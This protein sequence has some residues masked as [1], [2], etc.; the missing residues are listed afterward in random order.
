MVPA[1]SR[2]FGGFPFHAARATFLVQILPTSSLGAYLHWRM[3]T[4][5]L[6]TAWRLIPTGSAGAVLG[7]LTVNRIPARPCQ[8]LFGR[9][10]AMTAIRLGLV[11]PPAADRVRRA[12]LRPSPTPGEP[13]AAER[14]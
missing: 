14:P 5:D 3:G 12:T 9:F 1:F 11:R 6:G 4:L 10:L 13:V 8:V 2:F 7:I